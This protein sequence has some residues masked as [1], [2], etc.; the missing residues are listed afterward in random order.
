MSESIMNFRFSMRTNFLFFFFACT[1][2]PQ[3]RLNSNYTR[4]RK[5]AFGIIEVS[6]A[7]GMYDNSITRENK[8]TVDV[9]TCTRGAEGPF[10]GRD[11]II[12]RSATAA[13]EA[14]SGCV[15]YA[16][17]SRRVKN[18]HCELYKIYPAAYATRL[19]PWLWTR[20]ILSAH[21][22]VYPLITFNAF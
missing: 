2:I 3:R 19:H 15:R 4:S 7:N 13:A 14:K 21:P 8:C 22:F 10:I 18:R 1:V 17:N 6:R 11:L 12:C 16:A 9:C 20:D 5:G